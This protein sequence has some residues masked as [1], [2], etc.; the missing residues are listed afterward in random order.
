LLDGQ[1][2]QLRE[3]EYFKLLDGQQKQLCEVEFSEILDI[4]DT[5]TETP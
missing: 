2:K 3:E 4:S 1:Q 5:A